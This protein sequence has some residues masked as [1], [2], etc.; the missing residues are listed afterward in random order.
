MYHD[1]KLEGVVERAQVFVMAERLVAPIVEKNPPE[2]YRA[3]AP[4]L[5]TGSE[6][7]P[8]EQHLDHI[9]R[10]ADWLLES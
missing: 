5:S 2:K 8:G 7:T 6:V 3:G 1:D 10:V 9:I 4:P